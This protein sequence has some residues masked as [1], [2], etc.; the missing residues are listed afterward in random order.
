[1]RFT[2]GRVVETRGGHQ[3]VPVGLFTTT[4]FVCGLDGVQTSYQGL[5][6]GKGTICLFI[7]VGGVSI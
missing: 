6:N 2:R 3:P 4:R 5:I 7:F 1:M